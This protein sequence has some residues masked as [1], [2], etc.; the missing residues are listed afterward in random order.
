MYLN[1]FPDIDWI[2][3]NSHSNF[4]NGQDYRGN[5]LPRGGWP[6]AIIHVDSNAT[7]RNDI[8]GPFSL[9][10]NLKGCSLVRLNHDWHQ[11]DDFF[12][13]IS[14]NGEHFNLHI[15]EA[16]QTT[17]FNIHFG[18][19]LYDEVIQHLTQTEDWS[20]DNFGNLK[21][22][23]FE[24]LP[25]THFMKQGLKDQLHALRQYLTQNHT[26]YSADREYEST[27]AILEWLLMESHDGFSRHKRCSARK[28]STKVELFKR[29]NLGLEYIHSH[30]LQQLDLNGISRNCGLSRFHFIRVFREI[31][32]KTPMEYISELRLRKAQILLANSDKNLNSVA[33]ELGFSELSAFTRFFKKQTGRPPS[34]L[35]QGK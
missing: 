16:Q 21:T 31:Y 27:G 8:K 29:V 2:R 3:E 13:G 23:P 20:L 19:Q 14:N 35:R 11:I 22:I 26:P 30:N 5:A 10:Y 7:E 12:Y 33:A 1:Q 25:T 4:Q 9:F 6:T 24:V 32:H 34:A 18:K 15:P 28:L 17:T